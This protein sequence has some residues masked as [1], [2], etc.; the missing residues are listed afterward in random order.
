MSGRGTR[1]L[2]YKIRDVQAGLPEIWEF[3]ASWMQTRLTFSC[4]LHGS[5][6]RFQ[7]RYPGCRGQ[8][9][10][11]LMLSDSDEDSEDFF[12]AAQSAEDKET[13]CSEENCEES[14]VAEKRIVAPGSTEGIQQMAAQ[15]EEV[16][17]FVLVEKHSFLEYVPSTTELRRCYS[18]PMLSSPVASEHT[19]EERLN[20]EVPIRVPVRDEH[21]TRCKEADPATPSAKSV[22]DLRTAWK[23]VRTRVGS[24]RSLSTTMVGDSM[25]GGSSWDLE[26]DTSTETAETSSHTSAS[27]RSVSHRRMIRK[28][29]LSPALLAF[30]DNTLVN[31]GRGQV[32]RTAKG[33][34]S[35]LARLG[36]AMAP[37]LP[38]EV[39]Q[40]VLEFLGTSLSAAVP[41]CH[42]TSQAASQGD[43]AVFRPLTFCKSGPSPGENAGHRDQ[44]A[45]C[46]HVARIRHP[47][48]TWRDVAKVLA[49][50]DDCPVWWSEVPCT[51]AVPSHR[52]GL[53]LCGAPGPQERAVLFG[54]NT[55]VR[56]AGG[57]Q[58]SP[59]LCMVDLPP[60][61]YGS[62][63][64]TTIEPSNPSTPWPC[65]RWGATLTTTSQAHPA[66]P[67]LLWGGWSREGDTDIPWMLRFQPDG[68]RWSELCCENRPP[69]AAFHTATGLPDKKRLA[70]VGGLGN[71]SSRDAVWTFDSST[72]RFHKLCDGGPAPAGHVAAADDEAQRL[73]VCF[74]VRRSQPFVEDNFMKTTS[75]LDL[76]MGRWDPDAWKGVGDPS[77]QDAAP[78]A[79]LARRNAAAASLGHRI[80]VSGGYN[81]EE[82]TSLEDTW[83]FNMRS[84]MWAQMAE[85]GAPRMEGHKAILSGLDMF[86]FGGHALLGRFPRP[87]VSVHRLSLGKADPLRLFS[88]TDE[89]RQL[90]RPEMDNP[91]Q[92]YPVPGGG[93]PDLSDRLAAS[94]EY[95]RWVKEV[96]VALGSGGE[97]P[98]FTELWIELNKRPAVQGRS[99][100]PRSSSDPRAR[101]DGWS[102]GRRSRWHSAQEALQLLL[103]SLSQFEA[104][105]SGRSITGQELSASMRKHSREFSIQ[106]TP[107]EKLG[108][109]LQLAAQD[110]WIRLT[111]TGDSMSV[112]ILDL[113]TNGVANL[114]NAWEHEKDVGIRLEPARPPILREVRRVDRV[115][116]VALKPAPYAAP[117]ADIGGFP[118][119][120]QRAVARLSAS[121]RGKLRSVTPERGRTKRETKP[122]TSNAAS[123]PAAPLSRED[124]L[125]SLQQAF[126]T[127]KDLP[128]GKGDLDSAR[129]LCQPSVMR[130]ASPEVRLWAAKCL[131]EVLRIFVPSPPF[132]TERFRPI[133]EL[134][135]EQLAS[136]NPS[137]QT[138][139]YS[140]GLLE[141]LEEIRGFMLVFDCAAS[142][143]ESLIISLAKTCIGAAKAA[144]QSGRIG[145]TEDAQR[146]LEALLARLLSDVLLEADEVPQAVLEQLLEE[147]V[148]RKSPGAAMVRQ[149]LSNFTT[150]KSQRVAL[151][152]NDLLNKSLFLSE[153]DQ[154]ELSQDRLEG[155]LNATYE[156]YCIHPSLVVRVL[157]NLHADLQCA[158]PDRRRAITAFIA[159]LLAHQHTDSS[160]AA[161]CGMALSSSSGIAGLVERF[162][163]R[164]ADAD[165][166]VRMTAL[167]GASAVLQS[168]VATGCQ[169]DDPA[170]SASM[171][172]AE[173]IR[174]KVAHRCLDPNDAVRLRAV[175]ICT[176]IALASDDGL[177]F[178]LPN[179]PEICKR[180]LDKKP[181][182]REAC[183]Q[184]SAQLYAQHALPHWLKGEGQK[185]QKLCWIP[186]LLCEAYSVFCG[187]R[188]GY[189]AQIEELL[190]QHLLGCG[191]GL[192]QDQRA[193]A[194]VGL[195]S[196]ALGG[197]EAARQ[198]L[199]MLLSK[200]RDAHRALRRFV[201]ARLENAAP[202][203]EA[204]S[205]GSSLLPGESNEGGTPAVPF[206]DLFENLA[207]WSPTLD[208]K[209]ARPEALGL[210]LRSL[211][212]VRDKTL[213]AHLD[214]LLD[215]DMQDS[216]CKMSEQ[217]CELD[218]LLRVHRL[219]EIAPLIRRA[220]MATWLLPDQVAALLDVWT[221]QAGEEAKLAPDMVAAARTTV[222][223]LPQYFVGAFVPFVGEMVKLLQDCSQEDAQT[224]LQALSRLQKQMV[225]LDGMSQ[226]LDETGF[227]ELL[228]EALHV[229]VPP[230][231]SSARKF[232]R[233]LLLLSDDCRASVV[234][235]LLSWADGYLRGGGEDCEGEVEAG[236]T[237]IVALHLAAAILENAA[238]C[239]EACRDYDWKPLLEIAQ[240]I[241]LH[242]P[243]GASESESSLQL[244]QFAAAEVVAAGSTASFLASVM[245]GFRS[246]MQG[247]TAIV[248]VTDTSQ[249]SS[250]GLLLHLA[251]ASLRSLRLGCVELSSALLAQLSETCGDL[252]ADGRPASDG[253]TLL[254]ALQKF[255]KHAKLKIADRLRLCTTLPSIFCFGQKKHRD[256]GQK[257]LQGWLR[258][259]QQGSQPGLLDFSVAC[260]VHFLSRLQIFERE[261]AA[262]S[263]FPESSKVSSFFC[264]ALLHC[265]SQGAELLG[266]ALRVCDRTRYFVD[267]EDCT[268]SVRTAASV[269]R[270]VAEKRC[271]ELGLQAAALLQ[272]AARGSMPAQL[273][274][275]DPIVEQRLNAAVL[276]DRHNEQERVP[277]TPALQ[278]VGQAS[279]SSPQTQVLRVPEASMLEDASVLTTPQ[280]RPSLLK[281]GSGSSPQTPSPGSNKRSLTGGAV[282]AALAAQSSKK[283]KKQ[284]RSIELRAREVKHPNGVLTRRD[285]HRPDRERPSAFNRRRSR[286][287]HREVSL[288]RF[289]ELDQPLRQNFVRRPPFYSY[290]KTIVQRRCAMHWTSDLGEAELRRRLSQET[291][292]R[293]ALLHALQRLCRSAE[294]C[295]DRLSDMQQK[296]EELSANLR[297]ET[298]ASD[299]LEQSLAKAQARVRRLDDQVQ[300]Q[301]FLASQRPGNANFVFGK[302]KSLDKHWARP[303]SDF[304]FQLKACFEA[305]RCKRKPDFG[306]LGREDSEASERPQVCTEVAVWCPTPGGIGSCLGAARCQLDFLPLQRGTS[307]DKTAAEAR[308]REYLDEA[309]AAEQKICEKLKLCLLPACTPS[310]QTSCDLLCGTCPCQAGAALAASGLGVPA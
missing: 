234:Q 208:D 11:Y 129:A 231:Q 96:D 14:V 251:C 299:V 60:D 28:S 2:Y 115:Q 48:L 280:R 158:K 201:R 161:S 70:L 10:F 128:Q 72:E 116:H 86:T 106:K 6:A 210:H 151:P 65:S 300:A 278:D 156:L 51:G 168:V 271:P 298:E 199:G 273:F 45:R 76:R 49:T 292:Q 134:F 141:R 35:C 245:Q 25:H 257:M 62:V 126:E 87:T 68:P 176:H 107:F 66:G 223:Y 267:R 207:K 15:T 12:I 81:D 222:A 97:V 186:Q 282:S 44:L 255:Q 250:D 252:V 165:D 229:M 166:R 235:Q 269:L 196:S 132:E 295:R 92:G 254:H 193:L 52:Q 153:D 36:L 279:E 53:A 170:G 147:I 281:R 94:A 184:A 243:A 98:S 46:G 58:S 123:A 259:A 215:P 192:P 294:F 133:L 146:R 310:S 272:G 167:E 249:V 266:T 77:D 137:T 285:E 32:R 198:G 256:A 144:R 63:K 112:Q 206:A 212:A 154:A 40:P 178:M 274:A 213:W 185:A 221:G 226:K 24:D 270:Y 75:V 91:S 4:R 181:R 61:D 290:H 177:A 203:G 232:V 200:K 155:L 172:A 9:D 261:A 246:S 64:F 122:G 79:P 150:F 23:L 284:R 173:S 152:L 188:L 13:A 102:Q 180:I 268:S 287:R 307:L 302:K 17:Q 209:Y 50:L 164:L 289:R 264:E 195:C 104:S 88:D 149:V 286:S 30:G 110:G 1:R 183:A 301:E 38:G 303:L 309:A 22:L 238:D 218:R 189:V 21:S 240:N 37:S 297:K 39:L 80:I 67:A 143:V 308:L 41:C 5:P 93:G 27:P 130:H 293:E 108:K 26:V 57:W 8:K 139:A 138:Y 113:P 3:F 227:P 109:L 163:D 148:E 214:H 228:L 74:G 89:S 101:F 157:P 105:A 73:I 258:T 224:I 99:R 111:W 69:A 237:R 7:F 275:V 241:L 100:S 33:C 169:E 260:F 217:V 216:T 16:M 262:V 20:Q 179:L 160:G 190:E 131:A 247:S 171:A 265:D 305:A 219:G 233:I 225:C 71:G 174:T 19:R 83:S 239:G 244:L 29:R 56:V 191:A 85:Q 118:H 304:P 236:S 277:E 276:K 288:H 136:L 84:G 175:E 211:D 82:F 95:R 117:L 220:L 47:E 306:T 145:A 42:G 43:A 59:T 248:P 135:L 159:Q 103:D 205:S 54:G 253:D 291:E 182:I 283:A 31:R 162:Q 263:A 34:R 55:S 125:Q 242:P 194:L 202:L 187:A 127:L 296:C 120:R 142:D 230:F 140:F 78:A 121:E 114:A 124:A 18:M 204:R 119:L 197:P 90:C